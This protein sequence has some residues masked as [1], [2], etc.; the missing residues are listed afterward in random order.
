MEALSP[1]QRGRLARALSTG[2][3]FEDVM[4]PRS[5]RTPRS[6]KPRLSAASPQPRLSAA[7]PPSAPAFT[8]TPRTS[9]SAEPTCASSAA[10]A[11]SPAVAPLEE[12]IVL[13]KRVRRVAGGYLEVPFSAEEL[14]EYATTAVGWLRADMAKELRPLSDDSRAQSAASVLA[15]LLSELRA[16]TGTLAEELSLIE[17]ALVESDERARKS[18]D[19]M[20]IERALHQVALAAAAH[21]PTLARRRLRC[22][23]APMRLRRGRRRGARPR[24]KRSGSPTGTPRPCDGRRRGA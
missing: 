18:E 11:P 8:A 1:Y 14:L 4:S 17:R 21:A 13:P 15:A 3:G 20:L 6:P 5:A 22:P 7:S 12:L 10:P 16:S 24:P 2:S 19:A 23:I 9:S